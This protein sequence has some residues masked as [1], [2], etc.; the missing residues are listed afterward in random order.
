ML[1]YSPLVVS[2]GARITICIL[3]YIHSS[4]RVERV[5]RVVITSARLAPVPTPTTV[6]GTTYLL[7]GRQQG[8]IPQTARADAARALFR[9]CSQP[10]LPILSW[11]CAFCRPAHFAD[12][13]AQNQSGYGAAQTHGLITYAYFLLN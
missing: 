1:R 13:A 8:L 9:G 3:R 6:A 5:R 7:N 12:E 11:L 4:P 2:W 10:V